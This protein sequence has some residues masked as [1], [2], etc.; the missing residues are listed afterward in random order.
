MIPNELD[1]NKMDKYPEQQK[2]IYWSFTERSQ[3]KEIQKL[4]ENNDDYRFIVRTEYL[5]HDFR[6][7][8][9]PILRVQFMA[10]EAN[11]R[12]NCG[13][14]SEASF[15]NCKYIQVLK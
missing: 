11:K 8:C 3:D 6:Y 7:G 9:N 5:E 2:N 12:N 13:P 14:F 15:K 4:D 1:E 10:T